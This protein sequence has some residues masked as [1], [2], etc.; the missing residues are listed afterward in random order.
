ALYAAFAAGRP[1]PLPEL[2][3]QYADYAAWQRD[4]LSGAVLAAEVDWWRGELAGLPP[5][6]EL[7]VDRPRRADRAPR[8]GVAPIVLG[9]TT[10]T[11]LDELVRRRGAT[12]FMVLLAVFHA[13][14][15]RHGAGGDVAVGTPVAGR[16][17]LELEPLIGFFVNTLALRARTA[18]GDRFDELLTRVRETV[19]AAYAHQEVPFEKLVEE[20]APERSLSHAPL[21]QVMFAFQDR[22]GG[23]RGEAAPSDGAP[24]FSAFGAGGAAEAKF[25]LSLGLEERDGRLAGGLEYAAD[26][27]DASTAEALARRFVALLESA[28]ETPEQ[29]LG[30]LAML[31]AS[32]RR[33]VEREWSGVERPSPR[34]AQ[35]SL[36]HLF[37]ARAAE[38]PQAKALAWVE[39]DAAGG[40]VAGAWSYGEL[41]S[42]ARGF[43][44]HL[45]ALGAGP[46]SR[47]GV[48]LER[49]PELLV[50]LL[51][52][53]G[54]GAAYV[55]LDPAYPASRLEL[56][57]ADGGVGWLVAESEPPA[58]LRV[59]A[60]VE[61]I[62]RGDDGALPAAEV[63][64]GWASPA[65][66]HHLAYAI[67]T[68][69][70][71]GRPKGVAI[72]HRAATALAAWA[73]ERYS[74]EEL[75]GVLAATS[76]CF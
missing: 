10:V 18:P 59:P 19:I 7:P 25:D 14:L 30:E 39:T 64:A 74:A 61:V 17:R 12:R 41:A 4:W 57:L 69:G 32:E 54:C 26:L 56:M 68:S 36:W 37:A 53:L 72:E 23:E 3:V 52:T 66:A 1:S 34:P 20:L 47:V 8:A 27:F 63:A 40:E 70:S 24:S 31:S 43:A 22:A 51:G 48:L 15:A 75:A 76:V 9:E 13:L 5:V 62:R 38:R 65:A 44:A 45:S 42:R 55:P 73:A 33:Q 67:Y 46:E 49:S 11:A 6:V 58:G 16:T 29:P 60:A 35:V 21:V 28:L 2:A 71:T 50:A